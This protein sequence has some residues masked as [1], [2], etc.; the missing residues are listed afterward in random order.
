[1][2]SPIYS[3]PIPIRY[4][5][6]VR[7]RAFP[8]QTNYFPGP[9]GSGIYLMLSS[10]TAQFSSPL[11]IVAF[12]NFGAGDAPVGS[13]QFAAM[14]VFEPTN[15]ISSMTNAPTYVT[16]SVYHRR[17]S[18]TLDDPKPNLRVTTQDEYGG[19]NN[20]PLVGMPADND[21][22]FYAPDVYD[23]SSIHNPLAHELYREMGHYT[24]R[25]RFVEVFIRRSSGSPNPFTYSQN[26]G[27]IYVIEESIKIGKNRVDIN[28]L[29]SSDTNAPDVTGGY[30]LSVDRQKTDD[31]GNPIPQMWAAGTAIDCVGPDYYTLNSPTQ[32]VQGQYINDYLNSFYGA[33]YGFQ[34]TDPANGYAP[35]IDL[36]SWIDYHLHQ[37]FVFNVDML[38]LSAY[39]NKPRN[40]PLVQGP[41][42]DFDRSFGTG[43]YGDYRGFDPWVWRSSEM[44]GGTDPFNPGGTYW[45]PWYSQLFMDPDFFQKWIDRYEQ[46]RATVYSLSNITY[47]INFLADQL[48]QA[49]P[50]DAAK[51][52]NQGQSDTSP[53][54]GPVHGDTY[55]YTFPTPG[56]YK[57]EIDFAKLWFSNRVHFIDTNFLAPPLLS[58]PGGAITSGS[59]LALTSSTIE[60]NTRI[61]YTLDGSD[62]RLPG[63][64][65]SSQAFSA[66]N[67]AT[68]T[69]TSNTFVFARNWNPNHQNLTGPGNPPLS[70][71]W[72]GPAI[73]SFFIPP[74]FQSIA[75][76]PDGSVRLA[77]TCLAARPCSIEVSSNLSNWLSLT[78][79][80]NPP[81]VFQFVD[82]AASPATTR[83]YRAVQ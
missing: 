1:L 42:W 52:V 25:T 73:A 53:R 22:I 59:K 44:D 2:T 37:V 60:P 40:G 41:L 14:M 66:L 54:S 8:A 45:N 23:K 32:M 12:D 72:S 78:N 61:Y 79:F 65:A 82:T 64:A 68:L 39:F 31:Y 21:W 83:F 9:V 48:T 74:R 16:R 51:W 71:P 33:L 62:P 50:R 38:R 55:T 20:Q 29:Q 30:L 28:K 11:P 10:T 81:A 17:G 75:A 67:A 26:Y 46:L 63:G 13:D 15:G 7:A 4:P 36:G 19:N 80:Q 34:W 77:L 35:Y 27:G 6:I 76:L 5:S 57:G 49:A 3:N 47:Q 69:L 58:N 18:S 70:S 56:S 43:A 24:S